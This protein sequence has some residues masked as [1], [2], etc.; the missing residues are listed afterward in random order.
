MKRTAA[1][2]GRRQKRD[3]LLAFKRLRTALAKAR[4]ERT[5]EY[6]KALLCAIQR[7]FYGSL[8]G[9]FEE[10]FMIAAR[11]EE[12][13]REAKQHYK[14]FALKKERQY[15][16]ESKPLIEAVYKSKPH[17]LLAKR[18]CK[19]HYGLDPD[20]WEITKAAKERLRRASTA[21]EAASYTQEAA[22]H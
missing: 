22:S 6:K 20:R 16:E 12:Q 10:Y 14:S 3:G 7:D 19:P 21:K 17:K 2:R 5:T 4:R 18:F 13:L 11:T 15:A 8:V 9:Y 1:K